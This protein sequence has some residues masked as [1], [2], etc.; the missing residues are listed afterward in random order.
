[1]KKL[2]LL[3]FALLATPAQAGV[4]CSLPFNLQNGTTADATQVMANYNSLV[5]CLTNAAAAGVNNDITALT[6]LS[7]AITPAQGGT[8]VYVGGTSTGSGNAQIITSTV[9]ASF[10]LVAGNQVVFKAGFDNTGP[11]QINV[12]GSGLTNIFKQSTTG[13]VAMTGGEIRAGNTIL[14]EFDGTQ[15]QL[16]STAIATPTLGTLPSAFKN[17]SIKVASN[18]TVAVAGD[19]VTLYDGTST[20][21]VP[22]SSTINLGTSGVVN[23]LDTGTIAIDTWYSIWVISNGTTVGGLASTSA[24]APVM[25]AGYT[26][27]ARVGWV[28]TIHGSATLY[29]TWQLGR[30]AQ[31]VL[32]LAQTS[33]TYPSIVGGSNGSTMTATSVVRFA[34]PT[35]SVLYFNL[36]TPSSSVA[37]VA[38]NSQASFDAAGV[39][40]SDNN[41][42]NATRSQGGVLLESTNIYY[43]SSNASVNLSA[44]GW[45]DNL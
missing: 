32:G 23:S 25:P 31:Y 7:T 13:P 9:P 14:T 29:G 18:T 33:T 8:T 22:E 43:G 17:L 41:S 12:A 36:F 30:R 40:V 27:K 16:L 11:T 3:L 4:S 39:I 10:G 15:F 38:A 37:S 42:G 2:A 35:A 45:D 44:I 6:A 28:Q 34:P 1:M 26:F 21:T 19:F 24:T 5:A 20:V